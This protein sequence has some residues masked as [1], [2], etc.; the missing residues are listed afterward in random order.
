MTG[1]QG[2]EHRHAG[3]PEDALPLR[4]IHALIRHR[5]QAGQP[6][7][8]GRALQ[9]M[10]QGQPLR[11]APVAHRR[12]TGQH[13][14]STDDALAGRVTHDQPVTVPGRQWLG[15]H[16]LHQTG[17]AGSQGVRRH[18][19]S[20]AHLPARRSMPPSSSTCIS[21]RTCTSSCI[22]M[23]RPP[24]YGAFMASHGRRA[25]F[26]RRRDGQHITIQHR[27]RGRAGR[28]AHVHMHAGAAAQRP[29]F[30]VPEGQLHIEA[31]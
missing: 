11:R 1:Q 10:Q 24:F 23:H 4:Q 8:Q 9:D 3:E 26:I 20:V 12:Q 15:Q 16:Q 30:F 29:R 28:G 18:P 6:V 31:V 7:H 17:P 5:Q 2:I 22:F 21:S 25:P 14:A 27:Q 13:P 19:R